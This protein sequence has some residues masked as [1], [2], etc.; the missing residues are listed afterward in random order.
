MTVMTWTDDRVEQLKRLWEAGL[1]ASQI[2]AEL[3]T[4]E[5]TV[6]IQRGHMMRKMAARSVADLVRMTEKLAH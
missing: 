5:I 6:K 3:G 4:A 1:S 2:A